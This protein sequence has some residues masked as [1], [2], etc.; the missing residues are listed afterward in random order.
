MSTVWATHD[1]RLVAKL[2]GQGDR[3]AALDILDLPDTLL[4]D[5]LEKVGV[6][7]VLTSSLDLVGVLGGER[8]GQSRVTCEPS[9]ESSFGILCLTALTLSRAESGNGRAEVPG[10]RCGGSSQNGNNLSRGNASSE[11]DS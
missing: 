5:A 6:L 1:L 7:G 11:S 4:L 10:Q 3:V 9:A 8:S 2:P